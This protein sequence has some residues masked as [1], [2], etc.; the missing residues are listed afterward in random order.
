MQAIAK[1]LL[2]GIKGL[3]RSSTGDRLRMRPDRE[4][5]SVAARNRVDRTFPVGAV[6]VEA[7]TEGAPS[8]V[9]VIALLAEA[10]SAAVKQ[11]N[12]AAG[13]RQAVRA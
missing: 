10:V 12:K 5:L 1:A 8:G 9:A 11:G 7:L 4:S 3:L 2:T 13:A 6:I